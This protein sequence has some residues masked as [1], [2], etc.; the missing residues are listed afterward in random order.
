M[1]IDRT[2]RDLWYKDMTGINHILAH[3][4][5][6]RMQDCILESSDPETNLGVLVSN[7]VNKIFQGNSIAKRDKVILGRIK[8]GI[9]RSGVIS[10]YGIRESISGLVCPFL[11]PTL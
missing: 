4:P 2:L 11:A 3:A 10:V 9:S 1:L 7:Q 6:A 8:N 5:P